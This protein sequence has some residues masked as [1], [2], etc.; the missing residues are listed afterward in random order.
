MLRRVIAIAGILVIPLALLLFAQWPLRDWLQLYSRQANDTAQILFGLYAAVAITAAT[1]SGSHLALAGHEDPATRANL[2]WRVWASLAC[3]VP[4]AVFLLWTSVPQM[5][6]SVAQ[7][8]SFS[9]GL[10]PGYFVLR[11]ALV[12]L[13]VLVLAQAAGSLS[14]ALSQRKHRRQPP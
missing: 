6:A 14:A 2:S 4:W 10:T 7:W 12:M 9:E 11:I 13:P 5:L 1:I 8:E 3:V